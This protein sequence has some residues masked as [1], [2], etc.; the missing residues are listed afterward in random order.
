MGQHLHSITDAQYWN[1]EFNQLLLKNGGTLTKDR[2]GTTG[3]DQA[4][5]LSASDFL[6]S[7]MMRKQLRAH[8]ELTDA[9]CDQLGVLPSVVK[10]DHLFS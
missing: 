2:C 8:S 3:E 4:L 10:D 6:C 9:S 1:P 5:G 7:N